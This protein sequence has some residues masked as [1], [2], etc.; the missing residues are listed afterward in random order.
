VWPSFS[1]VVKLFSGLVASISYLTGQG[2][3]DADLIYDLIVIA[4]STV[5]V[6]VLVF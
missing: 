2:S 3:I 1:I 5:T 4:G 6:L